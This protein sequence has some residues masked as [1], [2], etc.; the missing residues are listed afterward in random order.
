MRIKKKVPLY[1]LPRIVLSDQLISV[2]TCNEYIVREKY[3]QIKKYLYLMMLF[4]K[5]SA[6][7]KKL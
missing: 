1:T 5:K 4:I 6:N 7:T 3:K 2:R